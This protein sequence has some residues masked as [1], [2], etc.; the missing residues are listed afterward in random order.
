V[1]VEHALMALPGARMSGLRAVLSHPQALAQCSNFF[2][3][4]PKVKA[5]PW[6]DTAGAARS[7]AEELES[8]T[9]HIPYGLPGE[10][11]A[12]ASEDAAKIYGLKILKRR[13]QNRKDNYTR[14]L[15]ISRKAENLAS[16]ASLKTSLTFIPRRNKPGVLH[17]VTGV[18]AERGIDLTK[19]ESRPDPD[20]PFD[21]RFYLDAAGSA[22]RPPLKEA[23]AELKKLVRELRVLGSYP[24]ARLPASRSSGRVRKSL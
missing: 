3:K 8:D 7:L 15:C 16:G 18:F 22:E 12:I 23:L 24:K 1:R 21:Y 20:N 4:H 14:F 6:Y 17:A 5:V 13:I 11:A 9:V 2:A 19:I 10:V